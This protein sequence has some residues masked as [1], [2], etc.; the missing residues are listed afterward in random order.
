[1][2]RDYIKEEDFVRVDFNNAPLTLTFKAKV[3]HVPVATGDS[4]IFE[5]DVSKQIYYVSE[6]CTLTKL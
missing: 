1:M 3:L 4:W 5:D 6:G 2:S